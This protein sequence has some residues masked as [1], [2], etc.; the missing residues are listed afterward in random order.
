MKIVGLKVHPRD[1]LHADAHG[2]LSIPESIATEIP[3][4]AAE[5]IERERKVVALCNSSDFTLETL[6]DVIHGVFP[7][8]RPPTISPRP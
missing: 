7:D 5:I 3:R 1:L 2:V 8:H 4:V 6:G